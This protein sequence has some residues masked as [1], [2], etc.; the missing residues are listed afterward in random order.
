MFCY[1]LH[2]TK[3]EKYELVLGI[4]DSELAGKVL[5]KNP[6]FK[7]N[8]QF[9]CDKECGEEKA[10]ELL[11]ECTIANLVGK[12]IVKL[13]LDKNFITKENVIL[14]QGIPHAQIVK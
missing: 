12:K 9:Y 14:I 13:A 10:L 4:C 8:K 3:V 7:V 5:R 2:R 11:E 6:E 1:K